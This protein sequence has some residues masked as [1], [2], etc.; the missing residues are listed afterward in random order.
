MCVR[1]RGGELM[2]AQSLQVNPI[3]EYKIGKLCAIN[4]AQAVKLEDAGYG[5]RILDLRKPRI[6]NLEFRIMLS[7]CYL[8]AEFGDVARRYAQS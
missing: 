2:E 8:L 4:G 1:Q 6:G 5:V 3:E 7:A